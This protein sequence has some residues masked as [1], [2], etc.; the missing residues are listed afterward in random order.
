MSLTSKILL[1]MLLG[2]LLGAGFNLLTGVE[3]GPDGQ[4]LPLTG[5]SLWVQAYLINGLFDALGQIFIA[6][7]K[8]LVVPMVFVSLVCGAAALGGHSRMGIMAGKTI[9]YYLATSVIALSLAVG[10]ALLI[11][12]GAG[13]EMNMAVEFSVPESPSIKDMLIDV[14]PS[15]PV[16]SMVEANM[17]QII[18]FALL[19]GL[20]ISRTP[21][22]PGKV[23]ANFFTNLNEVVIS[24]VMLVMQF[25][26]YG[27]FC[28][29]VKL[30]AQLGFGA[31]LDLAKYFF[32]VL[33]VLLLH[34]I[35]VYGL[36]LRS[37]TGL[38]AITF[39]KKQW[40]VML[41]AFSTATSS[42]TM[43][44]NL[45]VCRDELGVD[46]KIASFAIPLGATINMDGTSIMQGVA[47][48]FIAQAFGIDLGLSGYLMIILTATLA[49]IGT[50]GVPSVG[51]VTLAMV[52]QSAG[53][54]VEGI[55]LIIGVDRLLDMTRTAVNTTGDS[56]GAVVVA[57]SEKMLDVARFNDMTPPAEDKQL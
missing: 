12:P 55:A 31:I 24:L 49:S 5:V 40:K 33:F 53:L 21:G 43:P 27:V 11:K 36:L 47:A 17:L 34:A 38:S 10:F 25:A 50:A 28:L 56:V 39:F 29:L 13:I 35:V 41:F 54:P 48:I 45:R 23:I 8:L 6:S 22:E 19:L 44:F 4:L 1:A 46:N 15:N 18:V 52:L 37:F 32:T 3:K 16:E 57:K 26:P 30:F 51:L 9:L 2:F 7:L 14:F 20:A 42:A